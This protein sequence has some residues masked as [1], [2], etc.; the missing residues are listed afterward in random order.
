M[1]PNIKENIHGKALIY[2]VMLLTPK[3]NSYIIDSMKTYNGKGSEIIPIDNNLE[4]ILTEDNMLIDTGEP[5]ALKDV[6]EQILIDATYSLL[7]KDKISKLEL[8]IFMYSHGLDNY[9]PKRDTKT[10]AKI[11]R[12]R[13]IKLYKGYNIN[14]TIKMIRYRTAQK[15]KQEINTIIE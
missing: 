1:L 14:E 15:V 11:I 12:R 5:S 13:K 3:A 8:D 7:K 10:I 9:F 2:C 6:S 4:R